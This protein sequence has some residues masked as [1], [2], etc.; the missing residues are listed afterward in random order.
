MARRRRRARQRYQFGFLLAIEYGWHRR[1][2]SLFAPNDGF[3][4]LVHILFP[5][6]PTQLFAAAHSQGY[7]R[8]VPLRAP[9]TRVRVQQDPH[10]RLQPGSTFPFANDTFKPPALRDAQFDNILLMT[11]LRLRRSV[12]DDIKRIIYYLPFS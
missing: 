9:W 5:H 1:G 6:T 12:D 11:H 2:R 4:P 3:H 10:P 8:I 7:L